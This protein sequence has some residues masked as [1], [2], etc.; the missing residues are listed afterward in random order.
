VRA[1]LA[2]CLVR[3]APEHVEATLR[4]ILD[5]YADPT[6]DRLL[7]TTFASAL[8]RPLPFHLGQAA[9]SYGSYREIARLL[10]ARVDA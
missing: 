8:R 1:L 4:L 9:L 2:T 10:H 3:T 5:T 7:A 6:V